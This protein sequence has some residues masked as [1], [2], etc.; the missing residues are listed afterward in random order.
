M[1][2]RQDPEQLKIA[3]QIHDAFNEGIVDIFLELIIQK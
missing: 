1:K 3:Q 2:I